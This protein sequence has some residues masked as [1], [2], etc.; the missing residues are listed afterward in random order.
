MSGLSVGAV[1]QITAALLET[2]FILESGEGESTG[3]RRQ[4]FLRLNPTA[5]F[6]VGVKL[7]E[8]RIVCAITDF[9]AR[10]L[11]SH[12]EHIRFEANPQAESQLIAA[13]VEATIQKSG[14]PRDR[15]LG[16]GVGIAG[17]I[18][19]DSGVVQYSPY[20]GWRNVPL[21]ALLSDH[22]GLP[23]F[24][25][26]DVNT[27]TFTE[28][29]FGDGRRH[30]HVVVVT[31]GRGIGMG[32]VIA[33]QPYRGAQG[34]A[35]ELGHII[36]DRIDAASGAVEQGTLETLAADPAV[37]R[38]YSANG[39]LRT[40]E[41]VVAAA[42]AGDEHARRA[43]AQSGELLGMGLANVINILSPNLLII[44]GEGLIAGKYRLDP[45]F[46]ALR[47]H[48][49]NGLLDKVEV[50]VNPTDDHIWARGAASLVISKT[51]ESPLVSGRDVR[52]VVSV[53]ETAL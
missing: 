5:G 19:P 18:D 12:D 6:A 20:F 28:M 36:L 2:G 8:R 48:T 1:S 24:V 37:L 14:V 42:D 32:I 29:L 26:N 41:D 16:I 25:E 47:R 52:Q 10:V 27:L 9:E 11:H 15:L 23:V 46:E 4:V 43:L 31:I 51:F 30:Q 45:M 53:E 22:L 39:T 13:V 34:G 38:Q 40:I 49:F 33:G 50:R 3:G 35:G 17:V 21:A 44:S 7:M